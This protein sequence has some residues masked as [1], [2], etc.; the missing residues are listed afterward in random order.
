MKN[1][2]RK[3]IFAS[4]PKV[5]LHEDMTHSST[6]ATLVHVHSSTHNN[7]NTLTAFTPVAGFGHEGIQREP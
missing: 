7:N 6:L 1:A 4:K 5:K 3:K 2:Q